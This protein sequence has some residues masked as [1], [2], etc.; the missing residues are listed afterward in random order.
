MLWQDATIAG[1]GD[2]TAYGGYPGVAAAAGV[3]HPLWIDTRDVGGNREE[4]FASNIR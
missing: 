1:Y 4:V 2:S 3:V